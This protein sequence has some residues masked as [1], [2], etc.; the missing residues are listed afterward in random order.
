MGRGSWQIKLPR[1]YATLV[2]AEWIF[3]GCASDEDFPRQMKGKVVSVGALEGKG[4]CTFLNKITISQRKE[5]GILGGGGEGKE[6]IRVA[7]GE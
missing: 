3:L 5:M 1:R 7:E 6:R 2:A 4:H